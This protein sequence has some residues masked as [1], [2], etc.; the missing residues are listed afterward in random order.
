MA[1]GTVP[2]TIESAVLPD[3]SSGNAAPGLV[4]IQGTESNPKKHFLVATFDSA[5]DE[6]LWWAFRMP[7]NY[8]SGGAVKLAWMANTAS[9]NSVVWGASLGAVSAGDADTPVEH[10]NAAASTATTA[11]DNTE[12]RRLLAT[13]ITLSNLD[14]VAAGDYVFLLVYRDP[15][16]GSDT[17]AADAEL[18]GAV[19]E[20]TTT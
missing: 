9:A 11:A 15:D 12:A 8:A 5:T 1:T 18:I 10:A 20:Y 4:V 16:N 19:F 3:G 14:S 13:S 2:L 7:A 17:L 6:H